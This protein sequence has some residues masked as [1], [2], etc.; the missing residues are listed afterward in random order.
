MIKKL[1]FA[2]A[3]ILQGMFLCAQTFLSVELLEQ[4]TADELESLSFSQTN[5]DQG[6]KAYKVTYE[7]NDLE[8]NV[9]IVSG[10]LALPEDL[11]K[12]YPLACYQHGTSGTKENVPSRLELDALIAISLAGKGYVTV[13][14]DLLGLG[15]HEGVH[16]YVHAASEAWVAV[17]MMRAV[18]DYA[19]SQNILMNDQ[20]FLTG[21]SQGGHSAMALHRYLE[22]NVP[23]EFSVAAAA[24]MSGPY[25]I[26]EVMYDLMVSDEEYTRP[27]YLI[28]TFISYKAVYGDVFNSIEETFKEPYQEFVEAFSNHQISLNQLDSALV[29]Q[30][31]LNEGAVIPVRILKEAYKESVTSD[32]D[33]P[34]ILAMKDNDVFDWTPSAPTRMYYCTADEEVP[35]VNSVLADSVM[36]AN[37]AAD[38][39]AVDINPLLT[40]FL[41]ALPAAIQTVDFFEIYQEI[42]D[43]SVATEEVAHNGLEVFPIPSDGFLK[44]KNIKT[45]GL[46]TVYDL[47]GK[48]WYQ[49]P[50]SAGEYL[51]WLNEIPSGMYVL[52]LLSND[53]IRSQKI[54]IQ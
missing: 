51:L 35:F 33:H 8:G 21:Y 1:L 53:Y 25:S 43:P 42:D 50:V 9:A 49:S 14:P 2:I 28:N 15:D 39:E 11:T 23:G 52:S 54:I 7:T 5:F 26:S 46:L 44:V 18:R 24:P 20:V 38:V 27:G 37:G 3:M 29:A 19:E 22:Q 16:P 4:Y 48:K 32:P 47:T 30:L 40:H 10:L 6:A 12:R 13:A 31:E 34:M 36:D 45:D 41:C 17:D